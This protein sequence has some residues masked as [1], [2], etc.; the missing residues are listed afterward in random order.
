MRFAAAVELAAKD[1]LLPFGERLLRPEA[2]MGGRTAIGVF[3]VGFGCVVWDML[4]TRGCGNSLTRVHD[5]P[6]GAG[7]AG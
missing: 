1:E 6:P 4:E 2:G 7:C 5:L 3:R